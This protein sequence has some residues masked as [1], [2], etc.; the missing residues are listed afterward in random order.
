[1]Y[2]EYVGKT[3]KERSILAEKNIYAMAQEILS[4]AWLKYECMAVSV[5]FSDMLSDSSTTY[6]R[7]NVGIWNRMMN[8]IE[9]DE[10][11][12]EWVSWVSRSSMIGMLSG[13]ANAGTEASA[14]R[15]KS[16]DEGKLSAE[17]QEL[18]KKA[19]DQKN[20]EEDD[21]DFLKQLRSI[22]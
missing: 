18:I 12:K 5:V 6:T 8:D 2:A 9:S 10:D 4:V 21:Q 16:I 22:I 19:K 7:Y 14:H 1:M 11:A 3:V 15:I 17:L 13:I 20:D